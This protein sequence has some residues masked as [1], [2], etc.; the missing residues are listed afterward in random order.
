LEY[1]IN[2]FLCIEEWLPSVAL[3]GLQRLVGCVLIK[4][5][6]LL[7]KQLEKG[8]SIVLRYNSM[9]ETSGRSIE[10]MTSSTE[11]VEL[12]SNIVQT[13]VKVS[14]CINVYRRK[15]LCLD[16]PLLNSK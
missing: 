7:A 11:F 4:N 15:K 3:I 6:R 10:S 5:L 12:H 13:T 9:N 16:W 14:P 8:N 2:L 1:S